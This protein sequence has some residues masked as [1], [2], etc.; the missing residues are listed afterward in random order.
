MPDLQTRSSDKNTAAEYRPFVLLLLPMSPPDSSSN[1]S[2]SAPSSTRWMLEQ[3]SAMTKSEVETSDQITP[4]T[5]RSTSHNRTPG[6][7]RP[8]YILREL[9]FDVATSGPQPRHR[10]H[11]RPATPAPHSASVRSRLAAITNFDSATSL[12]LQQA[13][14]KSGREST[15]RAQYPAKYPTTSVSTGSRACSDRHI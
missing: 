9:S 3:P 11:T 8:T 1:S 4:L 15:Q 7:Q 5:A 14:S 12:E 2:S 10:S 6:Y 13:T